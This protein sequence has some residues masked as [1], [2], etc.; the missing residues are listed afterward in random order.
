[1]TDQ[2]AV[3]EDLLRDPLQFYWYRVADAPVRYRALELGDL[4]FA[5]TVP[6]FMRP[7]SRWM[8]PQH[9]ALTLRLSPMGR[10]L[11][12]DVKGFEW[13]DYAERWARALWRDAA[14]AP[15]RAGLQPGAGL[16][17]G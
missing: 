10:W 1:M 4:R 13:G 2:P 7:R 6:P 14:S 9:Y 15:S 12:V 3:V 5:W 8:L 16:A 11:V 17:A